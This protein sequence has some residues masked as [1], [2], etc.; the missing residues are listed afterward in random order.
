MRLK[1]IQRIIPDHVSI[2][3]RVHLCPLACFSHSFLVYFM[4]EIS[5]P[6]QKQ[7][8]SVFSLL[9]FCHLRGQVVLF[10]FLFFY[11]I[12]RIL[13]NP[14]CELLLFWYQKNDI[15]LYSSLGDLIPLSISH[16]GFL[17]CLLFTFSL[18]FLCN[19]VDFILLFCFLSIYMA[20]HF[21]R[22]DSG[23]LATY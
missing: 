19:D 14:K 22:S 16:N 12:Q 23:Q 21:C 18:S 4:F 11:Y 5:E 7:R 2:D 1:F 20:T 13:V 8:A 10:S 9:A 15:A 6:K 3:F 17:F